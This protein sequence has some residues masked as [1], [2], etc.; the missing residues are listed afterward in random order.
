MKNLGIYVH[1]PFCDR[2]C[3][4]CDFTAFQGASLKI[5]DYINAIREEIKL[6]TTKD[7][8]VDSVFIGGGTPSFI[9]EKYIFY[10]LEDLKKYFNISKTAEIT[11]ET[12]PNTFDYDKIKRYKDY[13]INRISV[14]VQSLNDK[15]LNILGRNHKAKDVFKAI[16]I[17]KCFDFSINLDFI[18]GVF[19][20][21]LEDVL[22]DLE[23]I[24][25]IN[26]DH[27]SYYSLIIEEKTRL[28]SLLDRGK[29]N[30]I[31]EDLERKMYEIIC[32]KLESFNIFQY[33]ISNFSKKNKQS[34]H[35]KKYW[36]CKEY[37]GIGLCSHSYLD[38]KRFSNTLNFSK[39]IKSLNE[40]KVPIDFIE[41]LTEKDKKFEYIIMNMRLLKGFLIDDFNNKF[42][43][44]FL[45]ENEKVVSKFLKE[46]L[47]E[48]KDGYIFFTK[49]GLNITDSFF[50]KLNY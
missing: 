23:E 8:L 2:I 33:E 22:L 39:Y 21:T 40:K 14:G 4:Y 20:Q 18:F 26:P 27:I 41:N 44:N 13:G 34:I 16:E 43:C 10:I 49:K 32:E 7:Y 38:G 47:I 3:S 1:I 15:I 17:I 31:N 42:N 25:K 9:D 46:N 19:N 50:V 37:I 48:I 24:R 29:I 30:L 5:E 28:K 36:N 35:N 45:S 6:K 12:N 11:I